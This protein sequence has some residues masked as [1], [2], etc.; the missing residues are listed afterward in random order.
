M[1]VAWW[2][3]VGSMEGSASSP[4][5]LSDRQGRGRRRPGGEGQWEP[6]EY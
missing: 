3:L 5:S 6:S 1:R 4:P 2:L